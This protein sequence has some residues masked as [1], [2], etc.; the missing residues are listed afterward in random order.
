MAN[1][2]NNGRLPQATS[3]T[4]KSLRDVSPIFWNHSYS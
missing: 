1:V 2:Y 3:D 4:T